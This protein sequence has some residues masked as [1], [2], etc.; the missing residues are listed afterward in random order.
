MGRIRPPPE[1]GV[2][3]PTAHTGRPSK[4]DQDSAAHPSRLWEPQDLASWH[5]SRRRPRPSSNLPGRVRF[6]VQSPP[7]TDGRLPD[8][9]GTGSQQQPTTYKQLYRVE[10][11]G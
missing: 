3:A 9:S 6:S 7:N 5:P 10:L 1:A 2:P 8:A 11:N 4:V